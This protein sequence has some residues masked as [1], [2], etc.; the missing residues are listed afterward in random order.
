MA[1]NGWIRIQQG[2]YRPV[3]RGWK[4]EK[5]E[6]WERPDPTQ[7]MTLRSVL[8][9]VDFK[10]PGGYVETFDV[11]TADQTISL[12]GA[13]WADWDQAGRLVLTRAGQLLAGRVIAGRLDSKVLA[14]FNDNRPTKVA[15]PDWATT[16]TAKEVI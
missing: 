7:A 3:S 13:N 6:I 11:C 14:D 10:H 8:Q 9:E 5:A 12:E 1:A 15:A 4:T 16:W 2:A